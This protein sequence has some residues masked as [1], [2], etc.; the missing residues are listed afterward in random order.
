MIARRR[1]PSRDTRTGNENQQ[2]SDTSRLVQAHD[3]AHQFTDTPLFTGLSFQVHPGEVIALVGPSGSGKSTILSILAGWL[4][5]TSGTI[6]KSGI[7]STGWVFQN[8]LGT[9]RR[10]ALDHV[11]LP[12]LGK[13]MDRTVAEVRALEILALFSLEKVALSQFQSLSGGESA[14]LML[15]R[16]TALAPDLLLVDEPTAQLDMATAATVNEVI[17]NIAQAQSIVIV[18]THDPRT[19]DA[20]TRIIDLADFQTPVHSHEDAPGHGQEEA[21]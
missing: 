19:R 13:G 7:E 18:A 9:A 16:A 5:P 2:P 1:S 14:R 8:P 21:R 4:A 12:L 6:I 10:T 17:A 20:C 15:A 3:L 11:V